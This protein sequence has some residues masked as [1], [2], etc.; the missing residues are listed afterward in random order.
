MAFLLFSSKLR[1]FLDNH[2][3]PRTQDFFALDEVLGTILKCWWTTE[4]STT[5]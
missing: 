2:V 5:K 3:P 4:G 1:N